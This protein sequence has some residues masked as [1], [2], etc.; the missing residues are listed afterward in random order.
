MVAVSLLSL[1]ALFKI[2]ING[3]GTLNFE[4]PKFIEIIF[5]FSKSPIGICIPSEHMWPISLNS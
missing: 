5:F 4:S 1:F 2:S 3:R